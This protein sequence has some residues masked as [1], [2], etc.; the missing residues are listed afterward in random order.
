MNR[1]SRKNVLSLQSPDFATFFICLG[2][3]KA[4]LMD[5]DLR[6]LSSK[7][8]ASLNSKLKNF[9]KSRTGG[10]MGVTENQETYWW[11]N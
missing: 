5:K 11:L 6:D 7:L 1:F 9:L 4:I 2:L 8:M 3:G 10:L